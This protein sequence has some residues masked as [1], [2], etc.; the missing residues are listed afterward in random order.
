MSKK[1]GCSR[2]AGGETKAVLKSGRHWQSGKRTGSSVEVRSLD[3]RQYSLA[4]VKSTL[5]PNRPG[6]SSN[7]LPGK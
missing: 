5:Q 4:E 6:K 3:V 1:G 2:E 7:P